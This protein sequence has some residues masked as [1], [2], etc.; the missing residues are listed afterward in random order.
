MVSVAAGLKERWNLPL[1][2]RARVETKI[3]LDH[4]LPAAETRWRCRSEGHV[5]EPMVAASS[6]NI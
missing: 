5:G 6:L 2:R 3:M 4:I 1:P